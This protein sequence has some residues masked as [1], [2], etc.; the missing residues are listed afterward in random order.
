MEGSFTSKM[1]GE[2]NDTVAQVSNTF[3]VKLVETAV[4]L[5]LFIVIKI[6][7]KF[8]SA[9]TDLITKLPI[10]KQINKL[11]AELYME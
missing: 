1:L 3:A 9:L 2:A 8:V 10:L 4:L 6:A 11:R 7:L 5:I